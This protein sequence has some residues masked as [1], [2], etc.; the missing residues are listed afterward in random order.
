MP[1]RTRSWIRSCATS[2]HP[3]DAAV[4]QRRSRRNAEE[5]AQT[6]TPFI[7]KL[8]TV[9]S[10]GPVAGPDRG[11]VRIQTVARAR[12]GEFEP[13]QLGEIA[14]NHRFFR[15]GKVAHAVLEQPV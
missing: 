5:A 3:C 12:D 9:A 13:S 8:R 2:H 4:A 7:Q 6:P 1:Q 11:L 10:L 15:C 14:P